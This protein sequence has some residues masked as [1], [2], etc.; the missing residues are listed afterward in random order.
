MRGLADGFG[1]EAQGRTAG[2]QRSVSERPSGEQW[3]A[4]AAGAAA[5]AGPSWRAGESRH[6]H[7]DTDIQIDG[8]WMDSIKQ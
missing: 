6:L 5:A 4:W 7:L 8:Q 3:S 2:E 1:R